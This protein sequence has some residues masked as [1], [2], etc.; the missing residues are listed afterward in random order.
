MPVKRHQCI[1]TTR[2]LPA[3]RNGNFHE[4]PA[5]QLTDTGPRIVSAVQQL[6]ETLHA[7][8]LGAE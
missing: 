7:G 8:T 2:N 4:I 1:R 3:V 6:A 5:G